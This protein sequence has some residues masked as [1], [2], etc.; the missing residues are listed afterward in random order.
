MDRFVTRTQ[1]IE[2]ELRPE[3]ADAFAFPVTDVVIAGW[4]GRD[5]EAARAYV[6]RLVGGG[7]EAPGTIPAFYRVAPSLLTTAESID[8]VGGRT[9]GEVE[10]VLFSTGQ[11]LFVGLGSDHTDRELAPSSVARAKQICAKPVAGRVW[12]YEE[13]AD[14]WDELVLR[15]QV[16][17]EDGALVD[18]Q[19]ATLG[20]IMP[21]D[22]L[23]ERLAANEDR[24]LPQGW[25]L[26]CGT[27]PVPSGIR[28]SEFFCMSLTDPRLARDI[29]H[30]YT[31]RTLPLVR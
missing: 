2:I 11:G 6:D 15:A 14:H 26:F 8:V 13:V 7:F 22:D 9:S 10:V 28:A 23:L 12:R 30:G 20:E 1:A 17:G 24:G 3:G 19:R 25:V 5:R 18:Y 16:P 27:V 29:T 4:S 21:V 31:I